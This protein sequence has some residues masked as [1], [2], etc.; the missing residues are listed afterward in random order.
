MVKRF[1]GRSIKMQKQS[2]KHSHYEVLTNQIVGIVIGWLIVYALFPLFNHLGQ[3]W[4]AT[5]SS[6][7]FFV[8]SYTRTYL[9]RRYFNNYASAGMRSN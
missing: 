7:L 3:V 5:I 6:V 9:I 2:R 8:S 4:V 1:H